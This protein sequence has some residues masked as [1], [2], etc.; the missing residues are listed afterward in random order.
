MKS[1]RMYLMLALCLARIPSAAADVQFFDLFYSSFYL[2]ESSAPPTDYFVSNFSA[3]MIATP[4]DIGSAQVVTPDLQVLDLPE[5]GAG[6]F[7]FQQDF[8]SQEDSLLAFGAG[9]YVF[10]IQDGTLGDDAGEIVKPDGAFW[11]AEIPAFTESCFFQMQSV[12]ASSDLTLEFNSFA[13]PEPANL[14]LTFIYIYD[15]F[16]AVVFGDYFDSA[17]TSVVVPAGTLEPGRHYSAQL[18]FSS[19][20][21]NLTPEFGGSAKIL[22]FDRV[23]RAPLTTR[24]SCPGDLNNDGYVDDSDFVIFAFAYNILDCGDPSMPVGCPADLNGDGFVDD[25]D[26]VVFVG[27]YNELIC[28]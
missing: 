16:G 24:A 23:T 19:R 8:A 11:S 13:A 18:Y 2:Q 4:G 26:F 15:E 14:S 6:Y 10:G 9:H 20:I 28:P 5:I 12:D 21:E 22:G 3:R 25:A 1:I 27:A 17:F 7:L